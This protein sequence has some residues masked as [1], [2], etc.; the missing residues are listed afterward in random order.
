MTTDKNDLT[1]PWN[2]DNWTFPDLDLTSFM[3][4]GGGGLSKERDSLRTA[5]IASAYALVMVISLFGNLLV[6]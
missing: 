3:D 5:I 4:G 2:S 1:D 6:V